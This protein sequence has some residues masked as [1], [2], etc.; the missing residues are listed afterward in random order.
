M[1]FKNQSELELW[2]SIAVAFITSRRYLLD[3]SNTVSEVAAEVADKMVE[4]RR[5]RMPDSI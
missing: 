5:K 1:T 2:S 4:E 3:L